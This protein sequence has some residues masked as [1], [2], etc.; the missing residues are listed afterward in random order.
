LAALRGELL[1]EGGW[2]AAPGM[3]DQSNQRP[4][5]EP[6]PDWFGPKPPATGPLP[7]GEQ[8]AA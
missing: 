2:P 5:T 1:T 7:L 3:A 4:E 6:N 8:L